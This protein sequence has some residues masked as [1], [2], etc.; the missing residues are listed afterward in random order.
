MKLILTAGVDPSELPVTVEVKG[1]VR[2]QL[3]AAR[4]LAIVATRGAEKQAEGIRRARN[5][6][7]CAIRE[8]ADEIKAAVEALGPICC[9]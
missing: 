3:P 5:S 6:R 8:H 1:R 2:T 9:R 7:P 4:G